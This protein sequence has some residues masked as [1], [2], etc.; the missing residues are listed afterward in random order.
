[1]VKRT[2][3]RGIA[4]A[5]LL[6]SAAAPAR[7]ERLCDPAG[8]DCREILL[9]LI[10]AETRGIDVAFWFMEDG[11]YANE[12]IKRAQAGVPV[13]V[14]VDPRANAGHPINQQLLDQLAAAGIPMRQRTASGILHWKMM[15]FAGQQ[16][17]EFS[18][19]NYSPDAL[20]YTVPY[21]N[22]V[23]EAIMF[24]DE[25]ATVHSFMQ[26]F[27]DL[28]TDVRSY[29][30]YANVGGT[31]V[32][33]Y[34]SYPISPELNFP[35][36]VSYRDRA[37][38]AYNAERTAIDVIMY[39]ITDRSH[40]D[41]II[42]AVQRGVRVRL[43]TEQAEYR[44]P[45][46]LWDSWNVDR[47]YLAGVE[48]RLRAHAGLNHQ[49]SV[50]LR[51]QG[52]TIFGSS[53][54]TSPSNQSQEEHNEFTTKAWVFQWFEAQF[55]RKW[56][57][58]GP[59]AETQPF[60]PLPPDAPVYTSPASGA[61][62][63]SQTPILTFAAGPFAH[64]Y[65]IYLG[66]TANPPLLAS[67]VPLGPVEPGAAPLRY[68][69]PPLQP[70]TTYYWRVVAKTYAGFGSA[71]PVWSFTTSDGP[72][73]RGSDVD[74]DGKADVTVY[75]AATGMWL[76]LE[77]STGY[78]TAQDRGWGGNGYTPVPGDFD[79]D[80]RMDYAVYAP[81]SGSWSILLSGTG[82][83]TSITRNCGG[84]GYIPVVGDYDGDGKS[85]IA[86]Y[87]SRTGL[88][89]AL[90][91]STNFTGTLSVSW[92]G[93]GYTAAP[94]DFDGDGRTDLSVYE[95]SSGS[96][97]VLLSS[98]GYTTALGRSAGGAD[99]VPVQADYDGD[100]RT[101]FA[102]YNTTTGLWYALKSSTGYTT[103]VSVGW[104]GKGYTPVRGDFDGDGRADLAVYQASTGRWSVLLSASGYTTSLIKSWGG[105]GYVPVPGYP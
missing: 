96:W 89:F 12:L 74:G 69:L 57:N 32:R 75:Q 28:W 24:S 39:R 33:Q 56:N 7:A 36:S 105:S 99:Y 77:S 101:D 10:R 94:G 100:G 87:N 50:V 29:A 51:S 73:S 30:N 18:G 41:A 40:T 98:S 65:D 20:V 17:V 14:L 82:F 67:A 48:I 6:A 27:D 86:V 63:V 72:R 81:A 22:Y 68:Q 37:V 92:G 88:W 26:R 58:T 25:P 43:I 44:D 91:S 52:M 35:P 4:A 78:K 103:A 59:S 46:R 53:N 9:N 64:V 104:G 54:W 76:T 13:R 8:E 102:V 11:R 61:T 23:D 95:P 2:L 15:L 70:R 19:A 47:L 71:G 38:A 85:D 31:L 93:T 80:G 66:T 3:I 49:K 5:V 1:M 16:Q 79:G 90:E 84:S 62:G 60:V 97:Y 42:A 45:T 21:A 83:T 55:D 34:P